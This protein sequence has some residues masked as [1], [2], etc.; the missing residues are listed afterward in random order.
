MLVYWNGLIELVLDYGQRANVVFHKAQN[1]KFLKY[2]EMEKMLGLANSFMTTQEFQDA[3]LQGYE[4]VG[5][6]KFKS[7]EELFSYIAS[8]FDKILKLMVLNDNKSVS[9]SEAVTSVFE[10]K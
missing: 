6:N 8:N 4:R 5:K 10:E 7:D 3:T 1:F 2:I 9:F